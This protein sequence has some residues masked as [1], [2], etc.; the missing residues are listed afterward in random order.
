MPAVQTEKAL[1]QRVVLHNVRW[2]TYESLLRDIQPGRALRLFFD[3][4]TLE[5]LMTSPLHERVKKLLA[6]FLEALTLEL[7][8]DIASLGQTTWKREDLQRG[9]EPDECYYIQSEILV[10]G[11]DDIQ[12]EHDPPPDLVIEVDIST[13]S[14]DKH[15]LYA[16]FGIAEAWRFDGERLRFYELQKDRKPAGRELEHSIAFPFL[17]PADLD[18]FLAQRAALGETQLLDAFRDW[19]RKTLASR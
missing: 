14:I 1:P 9:F 3:R 17:Q 15:A 11:R 12:L 7:G 4:G 19:V 18:R 6:R 10:R 13:S 2:S 16:A 8:I 5:I